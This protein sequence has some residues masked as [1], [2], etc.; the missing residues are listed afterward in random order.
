MGRLLTACRPHTY[1]GNHGSERAFATERIHKGGI[2]DC[3]GRQ[4]AGFG[5][6]PE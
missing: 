5:V 3:C 6:I 2:D 4:M 1:V